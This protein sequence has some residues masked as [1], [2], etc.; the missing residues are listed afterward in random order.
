MCNR[1]SSTKNDAKLQLRRTAI[2]LANLMVRYNIAPQNRAPVVIAQGEQLV[3]REMTW[4]LRGFEGRLVTNGKSETARH[5]PL[6]RNAWAQR[7]CV[8][9]AD[10][11]YEW[12][13]EGRAKL[14]YR[15]IR[16]DEALFWFAGLWDE[17]SAP[18]SDGAPAHQRFVILT[19]EA[20][21]DVQRLHDRMPLILTTDEVEAWLSPETSREWVP[22][23]VG[24]GSL[25]S[26]RVSSVVS[27][28][29]FETPEC[30]QPLKGVLEQAELW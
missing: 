15:F 11:F 19:R 27:T 18:G 29:G 14:P 17:D 21:S 12:K 23:G 7:R 28:P 8:I 16:K 3:S 2:V 20:N 6:F 22:T 13:T 4:G 5:K 25:R 1:Y 26:Y 10:G 30:I 9:P 24:E